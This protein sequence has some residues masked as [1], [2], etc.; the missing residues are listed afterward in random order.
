MTTLNAYAGNYELEF[1]RPLIA[2]ERQI[3]DLEH[4]HLDR[5]PLAS[6]P[7]NGNANPGVD[8][9]S[10]IRK[11]RQSHTAMLK[12]IYAKLDGSVDRNLTD[13]GMDHKGFIHQAL[14]VIFGLDRLE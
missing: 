11:L 13:R 12:K 10:D 1:E 3:N 14:D 5:A 6:P 2:L 7:A 9:R 8:F 4:Q